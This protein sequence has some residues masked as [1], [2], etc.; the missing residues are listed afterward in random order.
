MIEL[1][2]A[3][4]LAQGECRDFALLYDAREASLM[5]CVTQG[6]VEVARWKQSHPHWSVKRW[7]CGLA[8]EGEL[9]V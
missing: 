4:C 1:L 5:T 9:S 7:R 3:A 8:A 2:I 6:Q